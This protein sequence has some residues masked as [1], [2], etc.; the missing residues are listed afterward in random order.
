MKEQ[1]ADI[2][3]SFDGD[4]DR[5]IF[6]DET[7]ASISGD[8]I[9]VLCAMALKQAG[10]LR[11]DTMVTTVMS[12]L[13]LHEVLRDAGIKVVTSAVGD[14]HVIEALRK[15]G[16]S[17]GGENSGH[18]IFADH[19]TT[20][21][22]ILSAIQIL[23]IMKQQGKKI[24]DLVKVMHE[25]PSTLLNLKIKSKPPIESLGQ[26][27]KTIREADQAFGQLGRHLIR[28]SGTENKIRILVEHRE[29]SEVDAWTQRFQQALEQ[30][31]A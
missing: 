24:S 21:D 13:G 15:G 12:N 26:L 17:F 14:R 2:G 3:I 27:Q 11:H 25:Y 9:L 22:G 31:L 30:D 4:A 6:S 19:A 1:R 7:G 18:L 20:G 5:V 10:Q 8:R 23:K 29:K 16:F 28:Y